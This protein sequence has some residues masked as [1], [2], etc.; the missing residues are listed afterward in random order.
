MLINDYE[1]ALRLLL[2]CVLGGIVG[3]EREK[4]HKPAGLRTHILVALG[5]ALVT[6]VS[7]YAFTSFNYANKDPGRIAANIVTGIGFLGA[8]TIMREGTSVKGLTTAASIWVVAAIG[9]AVATGMY[10]SALITTFLVFL[11]LDGFFEK[12]LFRNQ[13]LLKVSITHEFKLREIGEIF[14]RHGIA[15]KHVSILP[16]KISNDIPVEFRIR[17][18]KNVD[19]I[20]VLE[21]IVNIDGVTMKESMILHRQ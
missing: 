1:M 9:M 18:P 4:I 2:A 6:I 10:Y 8:G 15:M 14:E 11:T 19:Y 3:W 5:A 7:M 20:R 12:L 16:I 13:Q 21:E 17:V